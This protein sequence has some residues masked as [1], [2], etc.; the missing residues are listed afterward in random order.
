VAKETEN[1]KNILKNYNPA[2][3]NSTHEKRGEQSAV[4]AVIKL[5]KEKWPEENLLKILKS[6]PPHFEIKVDPDNLL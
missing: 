6:L 3:F 1:L 5:P 2:I 4:N